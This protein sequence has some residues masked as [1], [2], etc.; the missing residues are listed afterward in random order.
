LTL[1]K[2]VL[3]L[4]K[5]KRYLPQQRDPVTL[6]QGNETVLSAELIPEGDRVFQSAADAV[7]FALSF[8]GRP[9][10]P[11]IRRMLNWMV[12]RREFAALDP[13]VRAGMI[14]SVVSKGGRFPM[15]VMT[16]TVARPCNC[17]CASCHGKLR[18][19]EWHEAIEIIAEEASAK[20]ISRARFALRMACVLKLFGEKMSQK[21]IAESLSINEDA[22]ARHFKAI[23]RWLRGSRSRQHEPSQVGVEQKVWRDAEEALRA[24]WLIR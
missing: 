15:A 18:N 8:T 13:A 5:R 11:A 23:Q 10:R 17:R 21:Q 3:L 20:G 16:A 6:L 9:P 14:L 2:D 22:V 4:T 12:S 24:A 1:V 7:R 19:R